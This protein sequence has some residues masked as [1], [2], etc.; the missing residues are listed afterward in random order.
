[1]AFETLLL[2]REESFVVHHAEPAAGQRHQRAADP[3]AERRAE[4]GAD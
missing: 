2:E 1:M 4:L 3:R